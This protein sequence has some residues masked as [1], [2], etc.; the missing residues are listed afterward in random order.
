MSLR[1]AGMCYN[2]ERLN[3]ARRAVQDGLL[4][5]NAAGLCVKSLQKFVSCNPWFHGIASVCSKIG[6]QRDVAVLVITETKLGAALNV[7]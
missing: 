6:T 2:L 4:P 3:S 7:K 1:G 5:G